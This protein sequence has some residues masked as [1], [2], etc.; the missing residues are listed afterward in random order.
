MFTT[1]SS[2]KAY[3]L[4]PGVKHIIN[5][6]GQDCTTCENLDDDISSLNFLNARAVSFRIGYLQVAVIVKFESAITA[7]KAVEVASNY[8]EII[9]WA[10]REALNDSQIKVA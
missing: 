10:S 2:N 7:E 8:L 9:G 4:L 3:T 5:E 1:L 6:V